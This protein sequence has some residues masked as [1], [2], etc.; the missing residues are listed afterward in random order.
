MS[1]LYHES[2]PARLAKIIRPASE[3]FG[4]VKLR[5]HEQTGPKLPTEN[6]G[7]RKEKK[8]HSRWRQKANRIGRSG[9]TTPNTGGLLPRPSHCRMSLL[10][11]RHS[12][13]PVLSLPKE[14]KEAQRL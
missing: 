12:E 6:R 13:L 11:H 1:I 9:N 8:T 3:A 7:T 4:P 2:A 5:L 10:S 14:P